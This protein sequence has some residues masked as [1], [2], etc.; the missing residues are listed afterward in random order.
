MGVILIK[1]G[2]MSGQAVLILSA[3][4]LMMTRS[5]PVGAAVRSSQHRALD[6]RLHQT[7]EVLR[8]GV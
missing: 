2:G 3:K 4:E 7:F 8:P 1:N 5:H 6:L